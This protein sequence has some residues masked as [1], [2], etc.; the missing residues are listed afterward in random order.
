MHGGQA[1][2]HRD[3][4]RVI[5]LVIAALLLLALIRI[6]NGI[7]HHGRQSRDLRVGNCHDTLATDQ[8]NGLELLAHV[9][10]LQMGILRRLMRRYKPHDKAKEANNGDDADCGD[11]AVHG[12]EA[13]ALFLHALCP[14]RSRVGRLGLSVIVII[15]VR[16][17]ALEFVLVACFLC[18]V[19]F[20]FGLCLLVYGTA[21]L[22]I[23]P[24]INL[25]AAC[26]IFASGCLATH[27]LSVP[28]GGGAALHGHLFN[29]V[30]VYVALVIV[31]IITILLITV[32]R[33]A[34]IIR[35]GVIALFVTFFIG[36]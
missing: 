17:L 23:L 13:A 9:C 4:V 5:L 28:G 32:L 15:N 7:I 36:F 14:L 33:V 26:G 2:G 22:A 35:I 34:F 27:L 10:K 18:L 3:G 16:D 12:A 1:H 11:N 6:I 8:L 20:G 19:I 24:G 30:F 21:S 31:L 29:N 25:S